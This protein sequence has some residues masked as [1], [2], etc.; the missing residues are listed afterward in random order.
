MINIWFYDYQSLSWLSGVESDSG[1][2][3][4]VGK[5]KQELRLKFFLKVVVSLNEL[6]SCYFW[7]NQGQMLPNTG[8]RT[9]AE[10]HHKHVESLLARVL[11]PLRS[12]IFGILE[13]RV[14]VEAGSVDDVQGCPFEDRDIANRSG[15]SGNSVKYSF[16]SADKSHGFILHPVHVL[17]V[18]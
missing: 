18:L 5:G 4:S 11:P 16:S 1:V 2:L 3:E 13:V 7:F 8:S 6:D 14:I 15:F 12:E 10:P 17:Q 9:C